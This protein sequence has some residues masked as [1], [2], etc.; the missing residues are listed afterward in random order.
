MKKCDLT[1]VHMTNW[2]DREW[3]QEGEV[4]GYHTTLREN[5]PN[6]VGY[7]R[8][9]G[10]S[11]F[12]KH[13]IAGGKPYIFCGE[14]IHR[15]NDIYQT[16]KDFIDAC[17]NRP[18]FIYNLVNH[19]TPMD[20]IKT[21]MDRFPKESVELVH[22]DELLIL[23]EKAYEQGEISEDL[24]PEKVGLKKILAKE[25]RQAWPAFF[26]GLVKY[27]N[28][29]NNGE[30]VYIEQMQKTAIGLEKIVPGDFLAFA[31]IWSSMKL[32]KLSLEAKGIYVNHK[33][34]ANRQFLNEF[35]HISDVELIEE[36][37]NLWD[38]WH[39][40]SLGFKQSRILADRLLNMAKLINN[41]LF[42]N[43]RG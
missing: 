35:K 28:R 29:Y 25:A 2:N 33:P 6:C 37:Q 20:Q 9:M 15:G 8:G 5:L 30:N 14:G 12:E 16:M 19:T 34:T 38:H 1:T 32:V 36:L 40:K 21:A 41:Q 22:L 31:T 23:I 10:E 39:Q 24:Y 3:W 43:G 4:P 13:Y 17:P 18:L 27:Q 7:V 42:N 26:A 11:A